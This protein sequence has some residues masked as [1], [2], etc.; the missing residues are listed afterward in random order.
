MGSG[1]PAP[2]P[3]Q[4]PNHFPWS[5]QGHGASTTPEVFLSMMI[6]PKQ[7]GLYEQAVDL[8]QP[9]ATP[10]SSWQPPRAPMTTPRPTVQG[11][12]MAGMMHQLP[13][14]SPSWGQQTQA[15]PRP[16]Q[17]GQNTP[18]PPRTPSQPGLGSTFSRTPSTGGKTISGRIPTIQFGQHWKSD[19]EFYD[20]Q[21]VN[22]LPLPR[23]IRSS[24]WSQLKDIEGCDPLTVPL[25]KLLYQ[26]SEN[27]WLRK[28]ATGREVYVATMG[29][30]SQVVFVSEIL[31]QVRRRGIDLDRLS[32][33][34]ALQDGL[35]V[36]K[37]EAIQHLTKLLKK[38]NTPSSK[39]SLLKQPFKAADL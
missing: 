3:R 36:D 21:K 15:W 22:G 31:A 1:T 11:C 5:Q 17:Y 12:G 35:T 19:E 39:P 7:P 34:K 29:E 27:F 23:A 8:S 38:G 33:R 32:Q 14:P 9:S 6:P 24:S 37:K 2:P 16:S 28:L 4:Y 26:G 25:S 13:P 10:V 20:N 30:V 18:T